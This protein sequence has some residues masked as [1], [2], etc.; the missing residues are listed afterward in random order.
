MSW[1]FWHYCCIQT[2]L[3]HAPRERVSWNDLLTDWC[4]PGE[5]TLHVSV[6]VEMLYQTSSSI[7]HTS[8]STWACEL[9]Y[10][11]SMYDTDEYSHAPRER[12]S[13]NANRKNTEYN[14]KVTLHVSVW[15]EMTSLPVT[16]LRSKSHAPR[17]RV[18]WNWPLVS[19]QLSFSSHAPRERVSWNC[20]NSL[21]VP[22]S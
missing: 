2:F 5:V 21:K 4:Y 19:F 22:Y 7:W 18:S 11:K 8:R 14:C 10:L 6:W 1:N 16:N 20:I 15:V 9:K 13:W 12:V 3:G 17:E